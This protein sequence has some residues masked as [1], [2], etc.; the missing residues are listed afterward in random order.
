MLLV[1]D[2]GQAIGSPVQCDYNFRL[3]P[4]ANYTVIDGKAVVYSGED[5]KLDNT[6]KLMRI[7]FAVSDGDGIK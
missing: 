2:D 4:T 5:N 7:E 6:L 3:P 1:G